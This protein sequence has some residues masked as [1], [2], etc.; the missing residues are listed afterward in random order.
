MDYQDK[1]I[2]KLAKKYDIDSRVVQEVVYSPLKFVNRIVRHISDARPIRIMYFGAFTQKERKNKANR[3]EGQSDVL[4]ENIE[5]VII[6]MGAILQFPISTMEGAKKIINDAV[7]TKDYEKIKL[8]WD[9]WQEYK[10]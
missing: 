4:L 9:A 6:V 7:K 10:K 8:I 1:L 5:E 2:R 3:M